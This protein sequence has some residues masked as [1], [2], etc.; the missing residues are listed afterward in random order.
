LIVS[1]KLS[2]IIV[3]VSTTRHRCERIGVFSTAS[4]QILTSSHRTF[5]GF[6]A[7]APNARTISAIGVSSLGLFK[8]I[9]WSFP[10]FIT[11][12]VELLENYLATSADY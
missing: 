3:S 1:E 7:N 4:E 8:V 12:F 5:D 2:S 6:I 11:V 10:N 9:S